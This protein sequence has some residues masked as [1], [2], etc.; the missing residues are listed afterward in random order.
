M[1]ETVWHFLLLAGLA[2]MID[3]SEGL[4]LNIPEYL[5]DCADPAVTNL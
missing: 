2:K 4:V 1:M 3:G 5:L